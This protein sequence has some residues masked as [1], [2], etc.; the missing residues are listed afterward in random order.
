MNP[1]PLDIGETIVVTSFAWVE[2]LPSYKLGNP[3]VIPKIVQSEDLLLTQAVACTYT[4]EALP[5]TLPTGEIIPTVAPGFEVR[6]EPCIVTDTNDHTIKRAHPKIG[7]LMY[8]DSVTITVASPTFPDGIQI[9]DRRILPDITTLPKKGSILALHLVKIAK[10]VATRIGREL[11]VP[12]LDYP[13]G[14]PVEEPTTIVEYLH[15][16]TNEFEAAVRSNK[17]D[18]HEQAHEKASALNKPATM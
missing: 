8:Y 1:Y 12:K 9:N 5:T 16:S 18:W 3:A 15:C 13:M 2:K 14:K 7:E 11:Y 10:D 4:I 6:V 17:S